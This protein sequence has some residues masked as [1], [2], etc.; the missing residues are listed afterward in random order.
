MIMETEFLGLCPV[1]N[2]PMHKENSNSHH[3]IPQLKG[4]KNGEKVRLHV[5]CHSKIHSLWSESELRDVYNNIETIMSDERM[6]KFAK[7]VSKKDPNYNDSNK[8][9][10]EHRK[11]PR[12]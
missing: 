6:Q 10:N 3:L 2:R 9:Q 7:F 11:K 4:G 5:I 8:M 1:C 12:R